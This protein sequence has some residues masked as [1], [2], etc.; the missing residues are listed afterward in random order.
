MLQSIEDQLRLKFPDQAD[1]LL[2][3]IRQIYEPDTLR[4]INLAIFTANTLEEVRRAFA[5]PRPPA[6]PPPEGS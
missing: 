6:S 4:A 3:E 5:A 1:A 2:A